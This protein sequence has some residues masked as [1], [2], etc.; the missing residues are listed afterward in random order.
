MISSSV[1]GIRLALAATVLAPI[2]GLLAWS[3]APRVPP[4]HSAPAG[5]ANGD[6]VIRAMHDKYA[7]SW[8]RTLSFTQKTTRR[9]PADTMVIETW[10]ERA[11][12]PGYLRIDIERAAG[13]LS[14]A[15]AG[16][17]LFV[18]R[19]DSVLTR[20]AMRNILMVMGFDVY[21]QPVETTLSVLAAE[22]FPMTPMR[23]D[24]WEGR[25]VYVF[26]AAAGDLRSNQ[27]WIDKERLLFMRAIQPDE[28]DTTKTLD[29]RFDNYVKVPAGWLS[30]TVELYR[31]GKLFQR[32]EYSDVRTNIPIDPKIYVPPAGH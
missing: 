6:A 32:E 28:R 25:P 31:D 8:Y 9:T 12:V 24:T 15:Y 18:W 30:E 29:F 21:R 17:S 11:I 16:E 7:N 4:M 10:R 26:G 3:E 14:I 27:L 13:N 1:I 23:E 20:A 19:G 2:G 22:H 5:P